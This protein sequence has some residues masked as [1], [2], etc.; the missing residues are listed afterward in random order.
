[1]NYFYLFLSLFSFNFLYSQ[2]YS[3][4]N[5]TAYSGDGTGIYVTANQYRTANDITIAPNIDFTLNQITANVVVQEGGSVDSVDIVYYDDDNGVPGN[6]IGNQNALVPT[7]QNIA[8][9]NG[10]DILSVVLDVTPFTFA[11]IADDS[12]TFWI[13]IVATV[14]DTALVW[15][16]LSEACTIG[17][18]IAERNASSGI[19]YEKGYGDGVYNFSG[20]YSQAVGVTCDSD[21][22]SEPFELAD[23]TEHCWS[24]YQTGGDAPG[25]VQTNAQAHAGTN[26]FYHAST[27]IG[28]TSTSYLVSP[29][30][31]VKYF[32]YLSF[33]Y[34]QH[35]IADFGA[36]E[37]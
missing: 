8:Y 33:W 6:Q 27:D 22:S 1:M 7:S 3:E 18:R 21:T 19:W 14:S 16:E 9:T 30:I 29:A 2:T 20:T 31:S 12:A 32:D 26:S 4:Y 36:S 11:G 37:V 13:S 5:L 25:F 24:L 28:A 34:Y 15:W 10:L 23:I 17:N 35:N